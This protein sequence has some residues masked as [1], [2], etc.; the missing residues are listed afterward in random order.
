MC[1][2]VVCV[3]SLVGMVSP[4]YMSAREFPGLINQSLQTS[5]SDYVKVPQF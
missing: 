4:G 3:L 5:Y 2:Y 1:S